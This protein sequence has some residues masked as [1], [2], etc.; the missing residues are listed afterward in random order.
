MSNRVSRIRKST[1]CTQW[2]YVATENNPA[3]IATRP[4]AASLLHKTSWFIGPQFLKQAQQQVSP[5]VTLSKFDLV[6]PQHDAE[7]RPE[8]STLTTKATDRPLSP[9]RFERFSSWKTLINGM[10]KLISV[11]RCRSRLSK[12]VP[13]NPQTQAKFRVIWS[14]QQF[15]FTEEVRQLERGK[16]ISEASPLWRLNPFIDQ[17]GVLRVGGRLSSADLPYDEKHPVILPKRHHVTTLLVR[18]HHQEVAHQG[19]HLT[20]GALRS[21]GLWII[22][23]RKLVSSLIYGC[24]ICRKLRGKPQEQKMSDLPE[25]RL[26]IEPLF[27]R[28]GLDVFGPWSVV[29]RRTR[30]GTAENKRWAVLFTCLGTRAV[31]IEVIESMSTSSFINALRRFFAIRG[32]SKVLRSDRGT[33]FVGACRELRIFTD[34]SEVRN[35]LSNEG[36]SWTFNAPHSSHMGGSWERMIGVARRI[37]D[38]MLLQSGPTRLSHEVL[39]TLMA[40]VMAIMNARPLVPVSTDPE[41]PTVLTPAMLLTQKA[42]VVSAP[43]GVFDLK[44]LYRKQWRHVQCL[45]DIFWKRWRQEYL[46]TLQSR[47]KWINDKRDMQVGDVVL[48][49]D[50]Q[51]KRNEW[52]IGLI[53]KNIPS[54]DNKIRKVEVRV[55]K[56]GAPRIYLRPVSQLILLFPKETIKKD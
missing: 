34:D 40:E 43:E 20:E 24:V 50:D 27:T 25:D 14:V 19:R 45:A 44:D 12:Q 8:V 32:P 4:I 56:Q 17:D 52:P 3:D 36:C 26:C 16:Q 31:H 13:Q 49:K 6:E 21:A 11:A 18:H 22:G 47:K 53:V 33:N 55:V 37:L 2:N 42:N 1:T 15:V 30:G 5:S 41:S 38:V 23:V 39:V 46:T 35:Y 51:T 10:A 7:I 29:S 54:Q 48:L 28:V 9:Q